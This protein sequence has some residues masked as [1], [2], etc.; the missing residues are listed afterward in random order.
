MS[1]HYSWLPLESC[2]PAHILPSRPLSITTD[3]SSSLPTS[4]L[5]FSSCHS[6]LL[7]TTHNLLFPLRKLHTTKYNVHRLQN[8]LHHLQKQRLLQGPP[9][10]HT[11]RR[12]GPEG[13]PAW[14]VL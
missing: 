11:M 5:Y 2:P 7:L 1:N 8:Q 14:T 3:S 6:D 10:K 4:S 13:L 9:E 12:R